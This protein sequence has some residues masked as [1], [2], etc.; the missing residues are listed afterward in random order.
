MIARYATI[1]AV[2]MLKADQVIAVE[3]E[4]FRGPFVGTE[5]FLFKLQAHLLRIHI[6]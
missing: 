4:E 3:V 1:D 6:A 5:I 2:L